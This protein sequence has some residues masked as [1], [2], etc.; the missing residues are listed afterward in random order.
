MW[1]WWALQLICCV[2]Q[3]A[4]DENHNYYMKSNKIKLFWSDAIWFYTCGEAFFLT[5]QMLLKF[6]V[7]VVIC[8]LC[9]N[10]GM[11]VVHCNV[12]SSRCFHL[13]FFSSHLYIIYPRY[14]VTTVKHIQIQTKILCPSPPIRSLNGFQLASAS[15]TVKIIEGHE[16]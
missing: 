2:T 15:K 13:A 8:N 6:F 14:V 16:R 5:L 3:V 11:K 4:R 7:M 12:I 1:I 10:E 9:L